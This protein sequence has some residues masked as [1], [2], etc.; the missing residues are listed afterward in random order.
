[1]RDTVARKFFPRVNEELMIHYEETE[2]RVALVATAIEDMSVPFE[3]SEVSLLREVL[4]R[5]FSSL[6]REEREVERSSDKAKTNDR[7]Y[8]I[9]DACLQ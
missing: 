1:M 3:C 2:Y 5:S 9:F 7:D 8:E 6:N 4:K